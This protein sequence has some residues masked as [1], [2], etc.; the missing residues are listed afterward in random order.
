MEVLRLYIEIGD[1]LDVRSKKGETRLISFGGTCKGAFFD[2]TI[3][4]HGVDTQHNLPDGTCSL[5]ARYIV[6]GTDK[7]GNKG[8]I[9]IENN[10]IMTA[11]P[12]WTSRPQIF[13]DLESLRFLETEE[14]Y[15]VM[16]HEGEQLVISIRI[17]E[18]ED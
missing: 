17:Y 8:R 15:G 14:L 16:E 9:F 18:K 11:E 2:G 12:D 3:L 10:G 1:V 7:E 13:T 4:P 5:S 6:E